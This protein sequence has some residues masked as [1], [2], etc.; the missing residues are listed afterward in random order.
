MSATD[1]PA[2]LELLASFGYQPYAD[3]ATCNRFAS[4][5]SAGTYCPEHKAKVMPS[6]E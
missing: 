2:Y 5:N 1:W 3:H 6:P 4:L